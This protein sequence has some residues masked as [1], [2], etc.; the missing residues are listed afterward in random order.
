[1]IEEA[2]L[3]IVNG[4]R[5]LNLCGL[6]PTCNIEQAEKETMQY[7]GGNDFVEWHEYEIDYR[8]AIHKYLKEGYTVNG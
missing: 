7:S 3:L 2:Y 5:T 4:N 6:Q 8:I 1:M